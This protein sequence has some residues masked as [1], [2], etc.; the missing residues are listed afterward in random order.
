MPASPNEPGVTRQPDLLPV[1]PLSVDQ[2]LAIVS[3]AGIETPLWSPDSTS[4]LLASPLGSAPELWSFPIHGGPAVRMTSGL[5]TVG[6]L[7][8]V[9]PR[10]SPD[11]RYLSWIRGEI[12]QTEVWLQPLDGSAP[13]ALTRLGANITALEWAPDGSWL[14]VSAN[15]H[16]SYD[17]YR[18]SVPDGRHQRLT[19]DTRYE[20]SPVVMPDGQAILHVRL[21]ETW[22]GHTV[23]RTDLDPSTGAVGRSGVVVEDTDFFDYHYGR[24]FGTP[25][26]S[27]DGATILF[28]SAR[29]DWLNIWSVASTGG[30]PTALAPE[31]GDQDAG[32]W[33]PD[34]RQV[35]MTSNHDANVS[36]R[37]VDVASGSS[38]LLVEADDA[39]CAVPSWSPDGTRIAFTLATPQCPPDLHVISVGTGEVTRLTRSV[40]PAL[41]CHLAAPRRADYDFEDRTIPSFLFRPESIGVRPNG[42]GVVVVHG[43]PTMQWLPVHDGYLQFLV[44]QGYT[45]IAPNIRGSSGYGRAFEEANDG[46]WLGGDLRDVLAAAD[47]L[48]ARDDIDDDRIAITGLSYGGIMAMAAVSFAPGAFAA[49]VSLSGY[50]DFLHMMDEQEFRHQ[51]LLRKEL[52]DPVAHREVYERASPIHAVHNATTPAFIAHGVGR[53]PS[54][55]AGRRFAEALER[56]YKTV[57][58]RTYPDEHYYVTGRDNLAV[59]WRD[60][61]EFLD[62]YL[63]L[64]PVRQDQSG[65]TISEAS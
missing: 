47:Q 58:Y 27:P 30:T 26:P 33:S 40:A 38:R 10:W 41:Q 16:G 21:D 13:F 19:D 56:E 52:G 55:D 11:G 44:G 4:V 22:T 7:A 8:S 43:G 49:A 12:G 2:Q 48:R 34:G 14:V 35:V 31:D 62:T 42:A 1:S 23:V 65:A 15:R 18:V 53:F 25:A 6:H 29:S 54:S 36:L 28:R 50:G 9:V 32:A 61:A 3:L 60:V 37:L 24:A 59:L 57:T 63:D 20:V 64:P 51:Q 46:D 5:G 39:V 45:V 17:I